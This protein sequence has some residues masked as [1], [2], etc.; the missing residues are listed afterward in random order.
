MK[1]KQIHNAE[2]QNDNQVSYRQ[3]HQALKAVETQV[4]DNET[5]FFKKI[6]FFLEHLSQTD[7]QVY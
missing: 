1:L 3:S 4:L 2:L 6:S 5:E 7:S